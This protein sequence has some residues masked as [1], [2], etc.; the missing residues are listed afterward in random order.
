MQFLNPLFWLAAVAVGVPLFL[1]LTRKEV[2]RP[3]PFASL[4]F[5]RRIPVQEFRRRRIRHWLLLA[6]RCLILVALV[7]AFTQPVI[8][9]TFLAG[10]PGQSQQSVVLLID[11]S[12]S[13]SRPGVTERARTAIT[14]E[15][16][17]LPG[18]SEVA[19]VRFGS[20]AEILQPWTRNLQEIR[21]QV[22]VAL[23]PS[24][25]GT[26]FAAG[27]QA[28]ARLF[29]DSVNDHKRIIFV[30]DLQATGLDAALDDVQIPLGVSVEIRDVGEDS[31]N[32]FVE[33]VRLDR[34]IFSQ[35]YPHSIV[36]RV[37]SSG[38]DST[39]DAELQLF[40]ADRL[41][42]RKSFSVDPGGS[43]TV[44]FSPFEVPDGVALGKLSL[45]VGDDLPADN[46]WYFTIEKA[47]PFEVVLLDD[48]READ[49]SLFFRQAMASGENLPFQVKRVP[50]LPD[51]DPAKMP[52]V[53]LS[54]LPSLPD[55][56]RLEQFV[57]AGGGLIV[58]LG[59]GVRPENYAAAASDLLPAKPITKHYGIAGGSQF[60]TLG[61]ISEQNP[62]FEGFK[63]AGASALSSA[64]FYGYWDVEASPDSQI[65]ASFTSG[66][67]ALLE[68]DIGRGKVLL[69]TSSLNRV[70]SDF[71]LRSSYLPF[72][73]EMVLYGSGWSNRPAQVH[74]GEVFSP[75]SW[76]LL[77][78]GQEESRWDIVDPNGRRLRALDTDDSDFVLLN[79]PGYYQLRREKSTNWIAVNPVPAESRLNRIAAGELESAIRNVQAS[80]NRGSVADRGTAPDQYPVWWIFLVLAILLALA[81]AHVANRAG[82]LMTEGRGS[83]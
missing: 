75:S 79:L 65:L 38:T 52:V 23:E 5:L 45:D 46:T 6:L 29:D 67:P 33:E 36:A 31:R 7:A 24:Y 27:L 42:E 56:A 41:V 16:A 14:D 69:F 51:L 58:T 11:D 13:M 12:L 4:M 66:S 21:A 37:S 70:W 26:T 53:V 44:T 15:I 32:L 50:V 49:D 22:P 63:Q 72:W 39:T 74:V 61:T 18:E 35:V 62:I 60:V 80:R 57:S 47:T 82:G 40:L 25:D 59:S 78:N 20:R 19:L 17:R 8:D 30:S 34:D 54:D 73:Q 68:R 1:H 10:V 64:Q 3:I 9:R 2:R 55:A 81:E 76:T 48:S 43:T 77:R 28:A 83:I 71:P